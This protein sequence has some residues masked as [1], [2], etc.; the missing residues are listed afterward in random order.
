VTAIDL[1]ESGRSRTATRGQHRPKIVTTL[2]RRVREIASFWN[3]VS[4]ENTRYQ[5]M[6]RQC[7]QLLGNF[8]GNPKSPTAPT[9]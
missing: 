4:T 2:S 3:F 6:S 7:V 8:A 9:A 1:P 5:W